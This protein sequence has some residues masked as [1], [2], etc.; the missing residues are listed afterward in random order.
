MRGIGIALGPIGWAI[1]AVWT[2]ADLSSPAYRVTVPAVI[3][4]AYMR[5]KIIAQKSFA[6]CPNCESVIDRSAK[7]CPN[8]AAPQRDAA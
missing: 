2:F 6:A 8:C 1:T 4:I 3:Q 7:F 5:N